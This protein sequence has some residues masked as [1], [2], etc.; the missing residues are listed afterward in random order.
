MRSLVAAIIPVREFKTTKL[1][2]GK[3]LDQNQRAALT[4]SLNYH[5]VATLQESVV[6]Q[7]VIVSTDPEEVSKVTRG[8]SKATVISESS[9]RGGVNSAVSDGIAYLDASRGVEKVL[10]LPSDLPFLSFEAVN[11]AVRLLDKYDLLINPSAKKDGTN[12][13]AFRTSEVIP[14]HYDNDSY[15]NH[16]KEAE[17]RHLNFIS[18][19]WAEFSQDLD[20]PSDLE[21]A[22][23]RF[24]VQSLET[25]LQKLATPN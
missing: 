2:L 16:L 21:T 4:A 25:L 24:N 3:I 5:V 9:P 14:F 8:L 10:I 15:W 1:R 7:V 12:L 6:S 11:R 18:V 23:K 22:L 19:E 17:A 13:L 20:D